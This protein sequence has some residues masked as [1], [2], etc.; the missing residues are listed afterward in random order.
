MLI[1]SFGLI[2]LLISTIFSLFFNQK[3]KLLL[4][5]IF[6]IISSLILLFG[7]IS[8]QF[9]NFNYRF[10]FIEKINT[11]LLDKCELF[12]NLNFG[13]TKI[14]GFFIFILSIISIC[15][16]LYIPYYIGNHNI[17]AS[18]LNFHLFNL[19][20]LIISIVLLTLTKNLLL[21]LILW[22]FMGISSF[23][24]IFF[25]GNKK[26]T[27]DAAI[28]YIVVMHISFLF[29]LVGTIIL[30]NITNSFYFDS[31]KQ[32]FSENVSQNIVNIK[33]ILLWI[34]SIGFIIK[35]GIFPFHFWLIEAHPA[36]PSHIS[37]FMSSIVIKTG[38]YGLILLLSLFG[39]PSINYSRIFIFAGFISAIIGIINATSQNQIKKF[40]AYSSVENAGILLF[41][42]GS[43]IFGIINES[44]FLY[45][46]S[47][48]A[49]I[50]FLLNHALSKS[51]AFMSAGIIINET[52]I[53]NMDYLG[54]L[55]HYM[56]NVS[57]AN[58]L[59]SISLSAL[60]PFGNFI[61]ELLVIIGY[62]NFIVNYK[63]SIIPFIAFLS[64]GII[65]AITLLAF[66]KYFTAIFLGNFRNYNKI[67]EKKQG[68]AL[69]L[70]IFIPI[71]F[72]LILSSPYFYS[73]YFEV[74]KDIVNYSSINNATY[75]LEADMIS[76][77][78]T[79]IIFYNVVII[80]IISIIFIYLLY[81]LN[82]SRK[83]DTW[84]CGYIQKEKDDFQYSSTSFVEP[85]ISIF[86][87]LTGIKIKKERESSIFNAN[88][89]FE[90]EHQDLIDKSI[91]KPFKEKMDKVLNKLAILQSGKTQH[92]I[93]YGLIFLIILILITILKYI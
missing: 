78:D 24:C 63:F 67:K 30:Y 14:S 58:F 15:I 90:F 27:I 85:F 76:L 54:G 20:V 57:T 50:I 32:F 86:K 43:A 84:S 12:S 35:L 71:I 25:D 22:E 75:A 6:L 11:I 17:N 64:I 79:S 5:S 83:S 73:I 45:L 28:Q 66:T 16:A 62:C 34:F 51:S 89:Y 41:F 92:Y 29:L 68:I 53:D 55:S 74:V 33:T 8:Y 52:N 3:Y 39:I 60:P 81:R 69:T 7:V 91:L 21:F 2:F 26:K 61:G 13:L 31:I 37:S 38:F 72:S 48:I 56:K 93:L 47:F 65:G 36:S 82:K 9:F 49:I 1:I 23:F 42:Y 77:K 87:S 59:T 4:Y 40:L 70:S 19:S 44:S 46:S 80:L 18:K 10:L 88:T